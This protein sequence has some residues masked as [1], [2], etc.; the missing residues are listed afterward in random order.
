MSLV[1]SSSESFGADLLQRVEVLEEQIRRRSVIV[2]IQD[3][4]PARVEVIQP[5]LAIIQEE[6]GAFV[7]SFVDANINASGESQLDAV[8]MLK[9]VIASSFQLFLKKEGVL[10]DE[11]RRQLAVLRHFV[12]IPQE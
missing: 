8:E 6:D 9:D 3:L 4:A 11:P 10:G 12:R 5:I 1:G 7:A 2:P